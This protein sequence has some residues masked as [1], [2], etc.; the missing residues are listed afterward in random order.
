MTWV[1]AM[2]AIRLPVDGDP[3][4]GEG[5]GRVLADAEDGVLRLPPGGQ[6]H[7]Q[8]GPTAVLAVVV[9][10]G[11]QGDP[12][13][14]GGRSPPRPGP[15]RRTAWAGGRGTSRRSAPSPVDHRQVDAGQ[16]RLGPRAEGGGPGRRPAGCRA[17][18]P[19]GSS[20]R[21]RRPRSPASR[22]PA[23][24][25]REASPWPR[26]PDGGARR[27]AAG[28]RA[29]RRPRAS[30][31]GSTANRAR[32]ARP[33]ARGPRTTGCDAPAVRWPPD[34]GGPGGP[35]GPGTAGDDRGSPGRGGSAGAR[36]SSRVSVMGGQP[37][38][39]RADGGW[40]AVTAAA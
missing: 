2:M 35:G 34:R 7:L 21:H 13:R 4:R 26:R 32:R 12:G 8:A 39:Q 28:A 33:P 24:R 25:G 3:V 17:W 16:E 31:T 1:A 10:F 20:R 5:L 29:G 23:T 15:R 11:D 40:S 9:G 18:C 38:D 27:P 19:R 30:T 22:C 6:R 14:R 36:V 37:S